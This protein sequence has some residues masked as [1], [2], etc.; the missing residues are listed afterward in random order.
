MKLSVQNVEL[1]EM[2]YRRISST[3]IVNRILPSILILLVG[4]ALFFG[5]AVNVKAQTGDFIISISPS[6]ETIGADGIGTYSIRITSVNGYAGTVQLQLTGISTSS[7]FQASYSFQP[8]VVEVAADSDTYSV[9]TLTVSTYYGY[10]NYPYGNYP[11]ST[12]TTTGYYYYYNLYTMRLTVVATSGGITKSAPVIAD[13]YYGY[14][15][16]RPD[17][18]INLQPGSFELPGGL[19][20][21]VNQ[22]LTLTVTATTVQGAGTFQFTVTPQFYD[23]PLGI[24]VSFNPSSGQVSTAGTIT[25][26]VN[27]LMTPQFL[28]RSG[29]YRLAIGINSLLPSAYGGYQNVI[30]T[31]VAIFTVVV[32]PA[33]SVSTNP[34]IL[35]VYIGGQDQK[36]QVVVTPITTGINQPILL[37]VEGVP[38]GIVASF[39][40]DTLIPTGTEP[41]TTNLVFSAPSTYESQVYPIQIFAQTGGI[42]HVVNASLYILP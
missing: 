39:E 15:L 32:P 3:K 18:T 10:G 36:M 25:F 8:S 29:T 4:T 24:Y 22:T 34:A 23:P 14:S 20:Q 7:Y 26:S 33:F 28:V 30:L 1:Q 27:I 2:W 41:A 13:V 38:Q 40:K 31:R 9:L 42:T 5:A 16:Y 17:L 12:T 21:S 11:P 35:N 19:S 6:R 37:H